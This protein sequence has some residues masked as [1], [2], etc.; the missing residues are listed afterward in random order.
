MLELEH[1]EYQRM[2]VR[3][4]NNYMAVKPDG[5]VKRK[6]AYEHEREHHQNHSALVVPKAAEMVLTQGIP[7]E[8]AVLQHTDIYDFCLRVKAPQ[9][10]LDGVPQQ[11]TCRY[12]VSTTGGTLKTIKPPPRGMVAGDFKKAQG[13]TNQEY[14]R[15]NQTGLHNPLIHTKNFSKYGPAIGEVEKG[16]KATVCNNIMDC[17]APINYQYYI[18]RV[19]KLVD[20]VTGVT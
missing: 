13:V 16:W 9:I 19:R 5:E 2:H 11:G 7:I 18:D 3:D 12:Y 8:M 17:S 6:G 10:E 20:P 4:V 15:Q 14:W 1:V